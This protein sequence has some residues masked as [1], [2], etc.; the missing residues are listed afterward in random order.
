MTSGL[1]K[2]GKGIKQD[3]VTC[4]YLYLFTTTYLLV[5]VVGFCIPDHCIFQDF[6]A[7]TFLGKILLKVESDPSKPTATCDTFDENFGALAKI[8][9]TDFR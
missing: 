2:P 8:M 7:Y 4:I 5:L 6:V 1:R 9:A 3:L